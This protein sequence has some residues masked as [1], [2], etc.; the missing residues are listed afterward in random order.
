[1]LK[2]FSAPTMRA[3]GG[4]TAMVAAI[5][6]AMT[7]AVTGVANA[8]ERYFT[9]PYI[10]YGPSSMTAQW[11]L[12]DF[13]VGDCIQL[14]GSRA[15]YIDVTPPVSGVST[16][17]WGSTALSTH[18]SRNG[19]IWHATFIFKDSTG[20]VLAESSRVS[21]DPMK[22]PGQTYSWINNEARVNISSYNF[23]V[24]RMVTM[25]G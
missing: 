6:V 15:V 1:M 20:R 12:E 2:A 24:T 10:D 7:G 19:D 17:S 21:G 18:P 11:A 16:I 3:T 4:R 14:S 5:I 25:K 22:V 9:T 23:A 8:S 13:Y